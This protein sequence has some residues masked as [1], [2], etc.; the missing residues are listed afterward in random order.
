M[1][2]PTTWATILSAT[3]GVTL[4]CGPRALRWCGF[5]QPMFYAIR[6]KSLN[7]WRCSVPPA[8]LRQRFALPPP[9]EGEILECRTDMDFVTILTIFVLACF[10]GYY[11]DREDGDEVH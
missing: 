1:A 4:G 9:P 6:Q 5:P 11:E 8:P 7:R 3:K 10:I 2:S